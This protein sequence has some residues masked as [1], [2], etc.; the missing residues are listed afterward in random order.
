MLIKTE[1]SICYRLLRVF[2]FGGILVLQGNS[3]HQMH[4]PYLGSGDSALGAAGGYTRPRAG[5]NLLSWLLWLW[6]ARAFLRIAI[7]Q[8]Q[9]W[10]FRLFL[11]GLLSLMIRSGSTDGDNSGEHLI[12]QETKSVLLEAPAVAS[13]LSAD[14]GAGVWRV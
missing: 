11:L 8:D 2:K 1:A 14:A 6:C 7:A 10:G 9:A 12:D 3:L 5:T 4:C 13:A